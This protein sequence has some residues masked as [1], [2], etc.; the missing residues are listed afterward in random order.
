[1]SSQNSDF[2]MHDTLQKIAEAF[3]QHDIE[4]IVDFF[5]E[6]G[7]FQLARGPHPYG[8]RLVGKAAIR[9]FLEN[10]FK[11]LHDMRWDHLK[12]W[13]SGDHAVTEWRVIGS[14]AKGED[15]DLM[16]CDLYEFE[17]GKIKVK[18]TFWKSHEPVA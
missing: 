17:N 14:N 18:D 13:W 3:N 8:D 7:V 2:D 11:S 6:D 12:E 5:A 4:A 10:R 15:I 9:A 16:G 1:M